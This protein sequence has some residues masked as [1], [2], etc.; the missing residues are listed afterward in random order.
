[1]PPYGSYDAI[2]HRSNYAENQIFVLLFL[3][4]FT[5]IIIVITFTRASWYK[6]VRYKTKVIPKFGDC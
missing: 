1:M 6:N 5:I 2:E 4:S 3:L